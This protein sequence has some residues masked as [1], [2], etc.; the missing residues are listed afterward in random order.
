MKTIFTSI[1]EGHLTSK[2]KK[3]PTHDVKQY[4]KHIVTATVDCYIRIRKDLKP[5]P[6]KTHYTFNLRDLSK[7]V[8]G[9]LLVKQKNIKDKEMLIKLWIHESLRVFS[10][11]LINVDDREK[12]CT[13]I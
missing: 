8:Q 4:S 9:I 1:L 12:F 5:S 11:R 2:G 13:Y 10:D 6:A 7:V 3:K